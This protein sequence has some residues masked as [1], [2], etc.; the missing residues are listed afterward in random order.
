M[1]QS[2]INREIYDKIL[3]DFIEN[4]QGMIIILIKIIHIAGTSMNTVMSINSKKYPFPNK[5]ARK[6]N[7][8]LVYYVRNQLIIYY[9]T[10][11]DCTK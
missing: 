2:H 3:C 8:N 10:G 6:T 4:S 7:K 9:F 5:I 1:K 11:L